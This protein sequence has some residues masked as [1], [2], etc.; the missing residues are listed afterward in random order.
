MFFSQ[1]TG[2]V[3]NLFDYKTHEIKTWKVPTPL[4][5]PLGMK[6]AADGGLWFVEF[7]ANKIARLNATTG[8]ID[9]Y[10]LPA[11]LAT[12]AVL[13]A[14]T[15]DGNIYFTALATNS[16]GSFNIWTHEIKQY[17]VPTLLATPV[18]DTVDSKGNVCK[19]LN[20]PILATRVNDV[21]ELII[22]VGFS[23]ATQNSLNYVDPQTGK[24]TYIQ[25]PDA[26]LLPGI[27]PSLPPAVDIAMHYEPSDNTMWFTEFVNNRI[28]RYQIS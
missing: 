25:Q 27:L 5:G 6:V 28:G 20:T 13:R 3:I 15:S 14:E 19:L 18:E 26:G 11:S 4:A 10:P 8:Q 2:N 17:V 12:P 21:A 16:I 23:T 22:H 1:T 7:L 9:E 24:F